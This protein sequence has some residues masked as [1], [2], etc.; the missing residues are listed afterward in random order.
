MNI[1][2]STEEREREQ[3]QKL[4]KCPICNQQSENSLSDIDVDCPRCGKLKVSGEANNDQLKKL[5]SKERFLVSYYVRNNKFDFLTREIVQNIKEN[6]QLPRPKEQIDNAILFLGNETKF[7]GQK[8]YD[9]SNVMNLASIIGVVDKTNYNIIFS[10]LYEKSFLKRQDGGGSGERL[11]ELT[12]EGW[13]YYEKLCTSE[14]KQIFMAM[15][16]KK[17]SDDELG[18]NFLYKLYP[19]IQNAIG[20]IGYTLTKINEVS[21][22]GE[23]TKKIE[24][25]IRR[26]AFVIVNLTNENKEAYFKAGFAH[27]IGK[28][29]IYICRKEELKPETIHFDIRHYNIHAWVDS[30][31]NSDFLQSLKSVIEAELYIKK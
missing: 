19:K 2:K 10:E 18:K 4:D 13:N 30:G 7:L 11:I 1:K 22:C 15:R 24:T 14:S 20:E 27:G 29:V 23:I 28:K 8:Y 17:E 21:H 6:H 16:F 26:S 31:D 12:I 9:F 25:E 5:N 3:K